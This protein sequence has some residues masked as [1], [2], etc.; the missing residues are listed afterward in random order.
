MRYLIAF[1]AGLTFGAFPATADA[2]GCHQFFHH[3]VAVVAPVVVQPVYY[4]VGD[5]IRLEA[6]AEKVAAIVTQK[7][8]A[9]PQTLP[10]QAPAVQSILAAKCARCHSGPQAKG[11]HVI[12]GVT[13]M[14]CELKVRSL[15]M[16]S[17]EGDPPP[18]A[19]VPV[20]KAIQ[21]EQQQGDLMQA[22]LRLQADKS[23][24]VP[25][26]DGGLQ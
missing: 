10:L 6:L 21:A 24:P 17:G 8:Q 13:P 7:L 3:K 11:G 25:V 14:S 19:M 5:N 15:E 23:K 16:L 12:D 22:M 18:A 20:I 1:V 9:A 2:R 26:P 4:S